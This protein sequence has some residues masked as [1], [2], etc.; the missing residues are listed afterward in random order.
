MVIIICALGLMNLILVSWIAAVDRDTEAKIDR[1]WKM[2]NF[3]IDR[4]EQKG[5]NKNVDCDC[6]DKLRFDCRDDC[7]DR[8]QQKD[9]GTG[10][11]NRT[12]LEPPV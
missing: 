7:A 2:V 3:R 1:L 6:T 9:S 8:L 11:E 10:E 4:I 5:E 12:R